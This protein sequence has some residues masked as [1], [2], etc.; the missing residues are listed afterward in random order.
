[1]ERTGARV[2]RLIDSCRGGLHTLLN[3]R[4]WSL[5]GKKTKTMR[6]PSGEIWAL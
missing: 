4:G 3:N 1:V 2:A 5:G 6:R